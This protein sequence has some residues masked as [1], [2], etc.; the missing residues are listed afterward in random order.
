MDLITPVGPLQLRRFY[1][2]FFVFLLYGYR[3]TGVQQAKSAVSSAIIAPLW[4]YTNSLPEELPALLLH[5]Q[6]S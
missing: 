6:I 5:F 2:Y 4:K 1:D 3:G